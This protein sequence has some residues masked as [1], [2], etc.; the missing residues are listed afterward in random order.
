MIVRTSRLLDPSVVS[1]TSVALNDEPIEADAALASRFASIGRAV[2]CATTLSLTTNDDLARV[3]A[4][5]GAD[6]EHLE[7]H[8]VALACAAENVPFIALLA[9]ANAVGARGREEW[10]AH[11]RRVEDALGEALAASLG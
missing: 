10:R 8:G 1:G 7:T 9:V 2:T 3:L 4:R 11:H 6:V 5:T